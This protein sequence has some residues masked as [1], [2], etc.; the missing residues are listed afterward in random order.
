MWENEGIPLL[1]GPGDSGKQGECFWRISMC[2][3][4]CT[5]GNPVNYIC[6]GTG[7]GIIMLLLFLQEEAETQ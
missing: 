4:L 1:L 6:C 7:G 2:Q 5:T 3:A